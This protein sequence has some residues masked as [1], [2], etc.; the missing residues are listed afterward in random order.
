MRST[1]LFLVFAVSA[2]ADPAVLLFPAVGTPGL[3]RLEG[4]VLKH[5]PA[6]GSSTLSKNLRRLS[7]SNWEGAS[8]EVRFAGRS[9]TTTSGRDGNFSVE[10]APGDEKPFEVGFAAAEARVAG[11]TTGAAVVQV[12][13]PD[14][15]FLVISDFDDTLAVTNV[16]RKSGL[17]KAALLEDERSQPPVEGMAAFYG[18]LERA[19]PAR[20][21]F[22]LVS[23]SPVQYGGRIDAF[24]KRHG[25]PTF[26]LYLRDLGPSTL[27][28]YK[29]PVIRALLGALPHPVVLVG[30][31]GEADP[32]VYRQI[33]TEFPGRVRAVYL[34]NAG[35]AEDA[36]RFAGA[37]LFSHPREAALDA[38]AR[39]LAPA[40]CV[41]DAFGTGAVK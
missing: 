16:V 34:R 38:A 15:P 14:A 35:R 25:F 10:F 27:K 9:A 13:S 28:D 36:S 7:A 4:R 21:G 2:W 19:G 37:L 5:A 31:S 17:V 8:V 29:Q 23:G 11:A 12:V 39:G 32:E 26:G 1:L 41:Q 3:V 6:G 40:D 22:A 24:L 18:C 33:A 20:P 30:D